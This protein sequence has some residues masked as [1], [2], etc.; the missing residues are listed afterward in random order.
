MTVLKSKYDNMGG[1][2]V[3]MAIAELIRKQAG[4]YLDMEIP[5]TAITEF[6]LRTAAEKVK[7]DL[8]AAGAEDA[9]YNVERIVDDE[10]AEGMVTKEDMEMA[11]KER[12]DLIERFY[13]PQIFRLMWLK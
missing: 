8:S 7:E 4:E 12:G 5:Q 9:S 13:V 6:K 10:D 11:C 3:D 2:N 1:Q